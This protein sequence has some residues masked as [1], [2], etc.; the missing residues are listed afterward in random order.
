VFVSMTEAGEPTTKAVARLLGE[1]LR[2]CEIAERLGLSRATI[3]RHCRKL[4]IPPV[5]SGA[6]YDWEAIRAY[7]DAGHSLNACR[8]H[9]GFTYQAWANAVA[10]GDIVPRPAGMPIEELLSGPRRR[11][12]VRL[13]LLSS[14]VKERRCEVC[15]LDEWCGEPIPLQLHHV[16]GVGDDNR[17]E[18][19]QI[20]CPNCH[21]QT[22]TYGG[23]NKRRTIPGAGALHPPS[24]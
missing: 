16:N 1:G 23:R 14:G 24:G 3:S 7:Y 2:Q 15:G 11:T 22:D 13:R 10:R 4:G 20:L 18:N 12:H 21:A 19:L 8:R 17:L 9:F 5:A 6:R